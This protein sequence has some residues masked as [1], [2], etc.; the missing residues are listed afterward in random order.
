MADRTLT[1]VFDLQQMI[2]ETLEAGQSLEK[3]QK[4][5]TDAGVSADYF[6]KE[7]DK[8]P[9]HLKPLID[10]SKQA[11]SS[12]ADNLS[13]GSEKGS[14]SLAKLGSEA[15][16]SGA[17]V[18]KEVTAGSKEAASGLSSLD[19]AITSL[20]GRFL[21]GA[22]QIGGAMKDASK[23][24]TEAGKEGSAGL[25][26]WAGGF[27]KLGPEA[28]VATAAVAGAVKVGQESIAVYSKSADE[29]GKLKAEFGLSAKEGSGLVGVFQALGKDNGAAETIGLMSKAVETGSSSFIKL[30]VSTRDSSGHLKSM[31]DITLES[32]TA[33]ASMKDSAEKSAISQELLGKSSSNNAVILA[34]LRDGQVDLN[35][36]YAD[37]AT[38]TEKDLAAVVSLQKAQGELHSQLV[39]VETQIGGK[40]VPAVTEAIKAYLGLVEVGGKLNEASG[41]LIKWFE[42]AKAGLNAVLPGTE[43]L[44][45]AMGFLSEV[46]DKFAGSATKSAEAQKGSTA[47]IAEGGRVVTQ[48]GEETTASVTKSTDA[49]AAGY[50]KVG[51]SAKTAAT[52]HKES[53]GNIMQTA[54]TMLTDWQKKIVNW[55]EVAQS[56]K[57]EKTFDE[58]FKLM[59]QGNTEAI[60]QINKTTN[61]GLDAYQ[62][63]YYESQSQ[64]LDSQGK[65][66]DEYGNVFNK[67]YGQWNQE[68]QDWTGKQVEL[69]EG[70]FDKI[71]DKGRDFFGKI[72]D[73]M[74]DALGKIGD[75]LGKIGDIHLPSFHTGTPA[76]TRAGMYRVQQD[77]TLFLPLG[78]RVDR[79]GSTP[80][81][82]GAGQSGPTIQISMP[83]S[84]DASN[85][86]SPREVAATVGETV[87]GEFGALIR[88]LP[89][90]L[91]ARGLQ[92]PGGV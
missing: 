12:I 80:A 87:R 85:A 6:G 22:A 28:L 34:K 7:L 32:L 91:M 24:A 30:G 46:H 68:T 33:L 67:G 26:Q 1:A 48:T 61:E 13:A 77:E 58:K 73:L 64:L 72:S 39:K 4:E 8:V 83:I 27:A 19:S 86:G 51:E 2:K 69:H 81:A 75:I 62:K 25:A 44:V 20:L 52:Q 66:I 92:L 54:D 71:L 10:Q 42:G 23:I 49:Q 59:Q 89:A 16:K 9:E 17:L 41:G 90:S 37:S 53:A 60:T 47:A 56:A 31:K 70:M 79:A 40:L 43:L 3:L 55:D 84:I 14:A 15:G 35:K 36:A 21:P 50:A 38:M 29:V 45:K 63:M 88:A 18:G 78:T 65:W 5:L 57:F 82:G 11:G 76:V 74:G